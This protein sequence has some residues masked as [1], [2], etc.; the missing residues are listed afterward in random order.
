[1]LRRQVQQRA[2]ATKAASKIRRGL[3]DEQA[4]FASE[5]ESF[6]KKRRFS[7]HENADYDNG[8][9]AHAYQPLTDRDS[10]AISNTNEVEWTDDDAK[11]PANTNSDSSDT[12]LESFIQPYLQN[13]E[14]HLTDTAFQRRIEYQQ[15]CED[16]RV[17]CNS[18]MR[19]SRRMRWKMSN[20]SL[21]PLLSPLRPCHLDMNIS[22]FQVNRSR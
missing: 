10:A 1:M 18:Q 2:A 11:M 9:K 17:R 13:S 20:S 7:V 15:R 22:D 4:W 21:S 12:S 14:N 5:G 19:L 6:H 3:E 16:R 8:R